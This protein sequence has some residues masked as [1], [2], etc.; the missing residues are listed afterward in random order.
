MGQK[1]RGRFAFPRPRKIR[2][3]VG[4][5]GEVCKARLDAGLTQEELARRVKTTQQAI[6]RLELGDQNATID[7]LGRVAEALGLELRLAFGTAYKGR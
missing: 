7:L 1:H 3:Q 6:S 5:G 2:D 4:V